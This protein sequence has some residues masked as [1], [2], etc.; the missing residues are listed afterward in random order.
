MACIEDIGHELVLEP[1]LTRTHTILIVENVKHIIRFTKREN[2]I[3]ILD[4]IYY[5]IFG[6]VCLCAEYAV[7]GIQLATALLK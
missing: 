2:H 1:V 6:R 5:K 7:G 4:C 3:C